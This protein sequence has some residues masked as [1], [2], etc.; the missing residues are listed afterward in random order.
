MAMIEII[1]SGDPRPCDDELCVRT[2]V[3]GDKAKVDVSSEKIYCIPC[4]QCLEYHERKEQERR[5]S[6]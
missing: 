1:H 5:S 6:C 4:A 2:L 3:E